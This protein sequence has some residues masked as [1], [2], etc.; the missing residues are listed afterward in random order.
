VT[1]LTPFTVAEAQRM[2]E[3]TLPAN[4]YTLTSKAEY[5]PSQATYLFQQGAKVIHVTISDGGGGT[6]RIQFATA[7]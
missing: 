2:I 5:V 4:S 1:V 3:Q 6:A 7:P